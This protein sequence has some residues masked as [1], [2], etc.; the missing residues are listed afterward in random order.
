[1]M[2]GASTSDQ[3][4]AGFN[5][6]AA[7]EAALAKLREMG[8]QLSDAGV[9]G[10]LTVEKGG[11]GN[12][13]AGVVDVPGASDEAEALVAKTRSA[14]E[15]IVGGRPEGGTPTAELGQALMPG[16]IAVVAKPINRGAD[17]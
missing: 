5:D 12:I 10:V 9:S 1:M 3:L 8:P 4:V 2:S 6:H 11:D 14:S 16:A 17:R 15:R 7:G 13:T